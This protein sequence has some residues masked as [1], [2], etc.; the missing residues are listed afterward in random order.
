L[1]PRRLRWTDNILNFFEWL[2]NLEQRAKKWEACWIN[3]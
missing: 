2:G 1:L 3:P